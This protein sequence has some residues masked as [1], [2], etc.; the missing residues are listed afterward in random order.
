MSGFQDDKK[1]DK[2]RRRRS[3][4]QLAK[5]LENKNKMASS[6]QP[7]IQSSGEKVSTVP[8]PFQLPFIK[9]YPPPSHNIMFSQPTS[10]GSK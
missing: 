1:Q 2:T 3:S 6:S 4:S 8:N 5:T 10:S 9:D 7:S